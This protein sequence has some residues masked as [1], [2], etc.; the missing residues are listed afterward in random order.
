MITYNNSI[1]S[2]TKVYFSRHT[3]MTI[4]KW[5][6]TA[7]GV[8]FTFQDR[9]FLASSKVCYR[10]SLYVNNSEIFGISPPKIEI[11]WYQL[12]SN[13]F[14]YPK[15]SKEFSKETCKRRNSWRDDR[16]DGVIGKLS[17][18]EK[19]TSIQQGLVIQLLLLYLLCNCNV[20]II[21]CAM[22]RVE[23]M[24]RKT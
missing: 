5:L 17:P 18:I 4:L 2:G 15:S 20:H 24:L 3:D 6:L 21:V 16:N 1:Y 12:Y 14:D 8:C 11:I 19:K 13:N 10:I 22:R 9:K 23:V 7:L